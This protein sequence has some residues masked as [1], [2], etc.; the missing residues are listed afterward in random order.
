VASCLS[1]RL[2]EWIRVSWTAYNYRQAGLCIEGDDGYRDGVTAPSARAGRPRRSSRETIEDAA[3]ELF[4]E[5][6]YPRTSVDQIAQRAGVSRASFFNYFAAK[7]DV[8]WVG[9]D[10][11]AHRLAEELTRAAGDGSATNGASAVGSAVSA[12][13][14]VA[15]EFGPERAPWAVTEA[16]AMGIGDELG[17]SALPRFAALSAALAEHLRA[18]GGFDPSLARSTAAALTAAVASAAVDWARAGSRRGS[19]APW[20]DAALRPLMTGL[21]ASTPE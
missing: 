7:S 11:S 14:T 10:D 3:V 9:V 5:Q 15:A 2:Q 8:L 4:L 16:E 20:V 18:R 19:L 17:A 6:G 1:E 21:G 13:L 12:I